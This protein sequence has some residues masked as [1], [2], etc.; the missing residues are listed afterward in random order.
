MKEDLE[1]GKSKPR[2]RWWIVAF[3]ILPGL[4]GGGMWVY[5]SLLQKDAATADVPLEAGRYYCPMHPSFTS[6]EPGNCA[7]CSMKLVPRENAPTDPEPAENDDVASSAASDIP[8]PPAER[9]EGAASPPAVFVP[10][11][12]QQL[13][14]VK[15][16][17][18]K[19]ASVSV[20]TRA[21]GKVAYDETRVAHIHTKVSGWVE[22][23]FVDFVGKPVR[24]GEPLF[25]LY[26]PDLVASQEEYLLALRAQKELGDSSF[27]RVADGSRRLLESA[28]RRLELWDMTAGQIEALEREGKV[29]RTVAI[30]SPVDGV[31]TER[32]AYHHGRYVTPELDLYTIVDL[33]RVWVLADVYEYELPFM[34]AGAAAEIELP[35]AGDTKPLR[36]RVSFV[37][38]FLQPATRTVQVRMEFPNP[39]LV[40]RPDMFVNVRLRT[41]LGPRV[42][43]PKDAVLDTGENQYAFVDKGEG[44]FEPR[45]IKVGPEVAEGRVVEEGLEEGER[46]VTAA[47]FILDSESRLKGAFDSL[48]RPSPPE[49]AG[50]PGPSGMTA[51]VTTDPSPAKVGKNRVRVE[52]LDGGGEPIPNA[53]VELRIFMPQMGS[54]APMESK[55]ILSAVGDGEYGGELDIPMAW[56]WE[57]TITARKAGAVIGMTMTSITA[58]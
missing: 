11:Q 34:K 2:R 10:P 30:H 47:N 19:R 32:A 6:D 50:A 53:E 45:Q 16:S 29:T 25:N 17:E 38:P 4:A 55:T 28:R 33:S 18:V 3:L 8:P 46:V 24:K 37:Y 48:G 15:L 26:S 39:A 44:Y 56:T 27:D 21:V 31:V 7:I 57:T 36:G 41:D 12:R 5:R 9:P 20:E 40:L 49:T 52:L 54:M 23:V 58:R 35:Y 51:Q 14:G 13:I 22:E 42:V 1:L 43:V